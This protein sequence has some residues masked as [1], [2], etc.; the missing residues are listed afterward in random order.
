MQFIG[1][2]IF[3]F[4]L[5]VAAAVLNYLWMVQ[6]APQ[7]GYVIF[8]N[9]VAQGEVITEGML[10]EIKLPARWTDS[11]PKTKVYAETLLPW[12]ARLSL[13][14]L[15]AVRSFRKGELVQQTD[16]GA[17]DVLPEY[18][19]LGP[20]RLI[21][22]GGRF[23]KSYDHEEPSESSSSITIAI[24]YGGDDRNSLDE[25]TRR[26]VQIVEQEKTRRRNSNDDQRTDLRL[27]GV[28]AWSGSTA[29]TATKDPSLGLAADEIA[30]VVPLP[31]MDAVPEV[32]LRE[33]SPQ[34]GFLVPATVVRSLDRIRAVADEEDEEEE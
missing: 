9:D 18:E 3:A 20:F 25:K 24:R 34:I 2:F 19:V 29:A 13:I 30:L 12:N 1:R 32:L 21:A 6:K 5:A 15:K 14:D 33:D 23:A 17:I 16:V 26:L 11:T 4:V 10:G 22:V 7:D 31:E 28:V 8:K 27:V